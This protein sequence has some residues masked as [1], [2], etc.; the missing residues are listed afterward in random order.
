MADGCIRQRQERRSRHNA[1]A[2]DDDSAV[3]QG[4]VGLEDVF[5]QRIGNFR[6]HHGT[7]LDNVAQTGA[8]LKHDQRADLF[9]RHIAQRTYDFGN[10]LFSVVVLLLLEYLLFPI[11]VIKTLRLRLTILL[12]S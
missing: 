7:G 9:A 12:Q 8:S 3:M 1:I 11:P 4:R 2:A 5:N 6:I 10:M